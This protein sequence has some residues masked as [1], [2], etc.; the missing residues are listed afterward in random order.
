MEGAMNKQYMTINEQEK[1]SAELSESQ[2]ATIYIITSLRISMGM[3]QNQVGILLANN[4][5]FFI[6]LCVKGM[7]G[8]D[9]SK[10]LNWYSLLR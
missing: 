9:Y 2:N 7:K 1:A 10:L 3:R 8:A 6:Q 5:K 4:H